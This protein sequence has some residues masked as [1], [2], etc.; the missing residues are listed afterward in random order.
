[1]RKLLLILT[2]IT[3]LPTNNVAAQSPMFKLIAK[4][5]ACSDA[6]GQ[7]FI[8]AAG[9]TNAT[10]KTAICQL[11][12]SLKDSLLWSSMLAIY[13]FVGGTAASCKWNLKDPRD[14]DAAYRLTFTGSWTF[15]STGGQPDG[16]TA[17]A[18][19]YLTPSGNFTYN[20]VNMSYYSRTS[21]ASGNLQFY[22]MGSGNSA[23]GGYSIFA[24]RAIGGTGGAGDFGHGVNNRAAF[25]NADGT[26]YYIA[27]AN[28]STGYVYKNG[29]Q[30]ATIALTAGTV[31]IYPIY[32]GGFNEG[33]VA[34]AFYSIRECAF[35]TI[36]TGLSTAKMA[37][38]NTIV[39]SF[40]DA[41]GRGVQ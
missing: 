38:L 14:L 4:N 29:I 39:E 32:I 26:G 7:A 41:L 24:N 27:A 1:M 10:Q 11:V 33:D 36:G 34:G 23:V 2:V 8:L 3:A 17:Y 31:D 19:S 25:A 20:N 22:E 21:A 6:D 35:S 9:I 12:K 18:N 5:T 30:V 16:S 37:T 40:N 28:S 15:S 13:P